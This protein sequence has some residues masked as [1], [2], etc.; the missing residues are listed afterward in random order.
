VWVKLCDS[1]PRHPKIL[2]AARALGRYGR[3][4]A[5]GTFTELLCHSAAYLT[6]G[7]ITSADLE[8]LND[9]AETALDALI[10]A[11]L[12]ERRDDGYA[13]HDYHDWNPTAASV[14]QRQAK[15]RERK[16]AKSATPDAPAVNGTPTDTVAGIPRGI[17][18]DSRG[19]LA[20]ARDPVPSRP[21]PSPSSKAKEQRFAHRVLVKLAHAVL[22]DVAHG[23]LDPLDATEDLKARAARARLAYDATALAH[24]VDSARAQRERRA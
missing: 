7:R 19:A 10:E 24:A 21:V 22:D 11:G 23:R 20:R 12:V 18:T 8:V 1:L 9:D 5:I 3:A 14:K 17:Q 16:R 4:R 2:R 15:D 13:I 6:D